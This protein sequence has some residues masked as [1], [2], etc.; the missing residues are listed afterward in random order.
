MKPKFT[1]HLHP[2]V[3]PEL[4][5]QL[6]EEVRK[7]YISVIK[8]I[9]MDESEKVRI[10]RN[11]PQYFIKRPIRSFGQAFKRMQNVKVMRDKIRK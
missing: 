7:V 5:E 2:E 11:N 10:I 6:P 8:K 1:Y 4:Y 9:P 3:T